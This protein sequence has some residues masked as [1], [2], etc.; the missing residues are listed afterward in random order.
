MKEFKGGLEAAQ[1]FGDMIEAIAMMLAA[2]IM[3]TLFRRRDP[4]SAPA[5]QRPLPVEAD[6]TPARQQTLPEP[7]TPRNDRALAAKAKRASERLRAE[8]ERRWTALYLRRYL[9]RKMSGAEDRSRGPHPK[10]RKLPASILA[11]ANTLD[12]ETAA[13]IAA[14]PTDRLAREIPRITAE[15]AEIA[16][17][18]IDPTIVKPNALPPVRP[19]WMAVQADMEAAQAAASAQA[20]I[21]AEINPPIDPADLE[22]VPEDF[23]GALPPEIAPDDLE[24]LNQT[25]P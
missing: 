8:S 6:P 25:S 1:K 2:W 9:Q 20:I 13:E 4:V 16:S 7:R 14:T 23:G 12:A 18:A 19:A 24:P 15:G 21:D 11:Y 3:Q 22:A 17:K 10:A 5:R